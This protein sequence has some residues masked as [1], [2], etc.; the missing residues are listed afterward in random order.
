[1]WLFNASRRD[2]VLRYG[3]MAYCNIYRPNDCMRE[4]MMV[5]SSVDFYF[6]PHNVS[7]TFTFLMMFLYII[8][9][10]YCNNNNTYY[11]YSM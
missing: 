5:G 8:I 6:R 11:Y 2:L 4:E 9:Y 10:I 3:V 7:G 1:M